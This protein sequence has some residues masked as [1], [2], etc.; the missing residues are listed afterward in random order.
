MRASEGMLTKKK[1]TFF[2][3][4]LMLL[5]LLLTYD[6]LW[7]MKLDFKS[8][9]CLTLLP[10]THGNRQLTLQKEKSEVTLPFDLLIY[11]KKKASELWFYLQ[12]F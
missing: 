5:R 1:S 4:D 8:F 2:S 10:Q 3:L 12:R 7:E 9:F 11:Q 6:S